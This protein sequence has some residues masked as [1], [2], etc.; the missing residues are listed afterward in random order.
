M[1]I[2][3]Y[4][5]Q[6]LSTVVRDYSEAEEYMRS[7]Y[8]CYDHDELFIEE[9]DKEDMEDMEYYEYM[10]TI[11]ELEMANMIYWFP[12]NEHIPTDEEM[13]EMARYYG[14]A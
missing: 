3:I 4:Q 1:Y 14:E 5:G 11:M 2:I 6:V 12:R 13:E 10:N 8:G 9:A 7:H